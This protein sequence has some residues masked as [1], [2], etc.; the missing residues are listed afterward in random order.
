MAL[1]TIIL[2]VVKTGLKKAMKE[3]LKDSGN[4]MVKNILTKTIQGKISD[5]AAVVLNRLK[6]YPSKEL[7][8]FASRELGIPVKEVKQIVKAFN[9]TKKMETISKGQEFRDIARRFIGRKFKI[10]TKDTIKNIIFRT[11]VYNQ[12]KQNERGK[13]E[14]E[15][16]QYKLNSDVYSLL[17]ELQAY[18]NERFNTIYDSG[19]NKIDLDFNIMKLFNNNKNYDEFNKIGLENLI[20]LVDLDLEYYY[21]ASN[22]TIAVID[23]EVY[24]LSSVIDLRNKIRDRVRNALK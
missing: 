5:S 23:N 22:S 11:D 3:V 20:D 15:R 19:G 10:T 21:S 6:K 12:Q 2:G 8:Q 9:Q 18:I 13:D 16:K 14:K 7:Y 17:R 4:N 1:G 24:T